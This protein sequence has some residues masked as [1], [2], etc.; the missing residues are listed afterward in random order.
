MPKVQAAAALL[1]RDEEK[2]IELDLVFHSRDE[3][4]K[5]KKTRIGSL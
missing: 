5:K 1:V 3:N 4:P 2:K